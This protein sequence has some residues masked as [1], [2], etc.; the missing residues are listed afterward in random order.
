MK[1]EEEEA[2]EVIFVVNMRIVE[3]HA[4]YHSVLEIVDMKPLPPRIGA[5]DNC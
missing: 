2:S 5:R 1:K 4:T 3:I